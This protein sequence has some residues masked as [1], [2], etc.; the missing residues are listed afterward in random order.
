[1]GAR[2]QLSAPRS[3]VF[4]EIGIR[5][6]IGSNLQALVA[7]Q[8]WRFGEVTVLVAGLPQRDFLLPA[9]SA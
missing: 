1:V 4:P 5:N 9:I 6:T 2:L 8:A 3:H 7:S